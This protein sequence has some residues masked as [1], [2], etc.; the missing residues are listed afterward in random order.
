MV[1]EQKVVYDWKPILC[2]FFHKYGYSEATVCKKQKTKKQSNDSINQE[3]QPT[4]AGKQVT[5]NAYAN[6]GVVYQ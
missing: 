4:K 2:S 1:I 6:K 3:T 5:G